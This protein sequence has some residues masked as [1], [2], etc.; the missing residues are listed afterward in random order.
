MATKRTSIS[1][2]DCQLDLRETGGALTIVAGNKPSE[3]SPPRYEVRPDQPDN[4]DYVYVLR[5]IAD[6]LENNQD[7]VF[8]PVENGNLIVKPPTLNAA[9]APAPSVI[10][11]SA[12]PKKKKSSG[13]KTKTSKRATKGGK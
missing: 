2:F 4:S 8:L 3:L 12:P 5:Q 10:I 13:R 1:V 7:S 6:A 9:A 11:E